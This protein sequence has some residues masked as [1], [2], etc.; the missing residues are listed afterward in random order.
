MIEVNEEGSEAAA[1]TAAHTNLRSAGP[2]QFPMIF[3]RPFYFILQD[4]T[5]GINLFMGKIVDPSNGENVMENISKDY[6][7]EM[8]SKSDSNKKSTKIDAGTI[9]ILYNYNICITILK[10]KQVCIYH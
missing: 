1:A 4:K 6:V 9:V 8:I 7:A 10:V 2:L 3:D 5:H